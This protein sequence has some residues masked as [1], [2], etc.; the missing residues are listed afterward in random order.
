MLPWE[1]DYA[2]RNA[3]IIFSGDI[4][5]FF[6]ALTSVLLL[7]FLINKKLKLS[8]FPE[9]SV[10]L[11]FGLFL[12]GLVIAFTN[13]QSYSETSS[14]VGDLYLGF[15]SEVFFY[16]LLPSIVFNSGFHVHSDHFFKNFAGILNLAIFGTI[17]STIIVGLGLYEIGRA[18][19]R[20]RV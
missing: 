17:I 16:G 7:Q 5:V 20:E 4:L 1:S 8:I 12:G 10:T 18:S 6:I 11:V 3:A 2:Q 9:A 14:S 19:C 13:H 15:S